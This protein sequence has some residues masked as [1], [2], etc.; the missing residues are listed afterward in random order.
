MDIGNEKYF[1]MR[2][3]FLADLTKLIPEA[4]DEERL[5]C[6]ASAAYHAIFDTEARSARSLAELCCSEC[7]EEAR[8]S[9]F[10]VTAWLEC[11][12]Y[13]E[14]GVFADFDLMLFLAG[15]A[16]FWRSF[17]YFFEDEEGGYSLFYQKEYETLWKIA[18]LND[19][20]FNR[21]LLHVLLK[22]DYE[23]SLIHLKLLISS[24]SPYA[25][26]IKAVT[27]NPSNCEA[28]LK[29]TEKKIFTFNDV[30]LSNCGRKRYFWM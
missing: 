17:K 12:G 18:E 15:E 20:T 8:P 3:H 23:M 22:L 13:D 16:L 6:L 28:V 11:L 2:E 25:D 1:D 26:G 21:V 4:P 9:V 24:Y 27:S 5:G 14:K 19:P 29:M 30:V 10:A 7:K